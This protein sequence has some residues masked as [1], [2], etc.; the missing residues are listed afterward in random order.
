MGGGIKLKTLQKIILGGI[1]IAWIVYLKN[2][3]IKYK[4]GQKDSV[5]NLDDAQNTSLIVSKLKIHIN[6][7][8]R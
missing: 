1:I 4:Q 7:I 8:P 6:N 5:L 2:V 3:L